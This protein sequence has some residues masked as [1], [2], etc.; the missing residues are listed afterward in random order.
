[1]TTTTITPSEGINEHN[2]CTVVALTTV[3]GSPYSTVHKV[4]ADHGRRNRGRIA[5][6]PILQS[7]AHDLGLTARVV[8]RSGSV[9]RLLRDHPV[10]RLVV[11]TRGHAFAVIDGVIHDTHTTSPLCHV[12]CAWL[13][14]PTPNP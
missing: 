4:F 13:I 10:A 11:T 5:L 7:I 9:E 2:D 12:K 14:T 1:M 6:K 8:R 3:S